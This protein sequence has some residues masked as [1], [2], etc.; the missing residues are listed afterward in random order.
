MKLWGED[1]LLS[2]PGAMEPIIHKRDAYM[3]RACAAAASGKQ[4]GLTPAYVLTRAPAG[5]GSGAPAAAVLQYA[6]PTGGEAGACPPGTGAGQYRPLPGPAT[7]VAVSGSNGGAMDCMLASAVA[8][9]QLAWRENGASLLQALA[10]SCHTPAS[11][12]APPLQVVGTA[13]VRGMIREWPAAQADP[14]LRALL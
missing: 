4:Q 9:G 6:M 1:A 8:A 13:H 12:R 5:G 3:A 14:S 7:V 2:W 11:R 10:A